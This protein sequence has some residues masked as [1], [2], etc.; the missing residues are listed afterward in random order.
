MGGALL[1]CSIHQSS[2][3]GSLQYTQL[4]QLARQLRLRELS[5]AL[6]K[7]LSKGRARVV[8]GDLTWCCT[9]KC[10]LSKWNPKTL[11]ASKVE[12]KD[13]FEA[14][15]SRRFFLVKNVKSTFAPLNTEN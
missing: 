7:P 8:F 11:T 2:A 12:P 14:Y 6:C 5:I 15:S 1:I 4:S 3:R 10:Q 9:C 13:G